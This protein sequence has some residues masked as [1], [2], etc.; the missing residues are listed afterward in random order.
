MSDKI[1][2]PEQYPSDILQ[3]IAVNQI[4]YGV[5]DKKIAVVLEF[6]GEMYLVNADSNEAVFKAEAKGPIFDNTNKVNV[7]HFDFSSVTD[8][9]NYYIASEK[10]RSYTFAI[11][12]KPIHDVSYAILRMLYFQ[13]CSCGLDEKYAGKYKHG[14][15]HNVAAIY[16][17]DERLTVRDICGGWH[18]AGDYGRYITPANQCIH[19]LMYAHELFGSGVDDDFNIPETGS[20]LPDILSEAK[21]EIKWMLKMQ[22]PQGGVYH[23]V[24]TTR[25]AGNDMPEND[26]AEDNPMVLSQISLQATAGF[27]AAMAAAYRAYKPY[28]GQFADTLLAAAKRAYD[29]A[30]KNENNI[31]VE[32]KTIAPGG[33]GTYGDLCCYDEY[34]WA[35][36]E[37][38]RSTGDKKYEEKFKHYYELDFPKTAC[39]A[40]HQGGYGS[41]A[42]CLCDNADEQL[43][44][45]ILKIITDR[46]DELVKISQNDGYLVSLTD[47]DYYWGSNAALFNSL[48]IMVAAAI[49]NKTDKYDDCLKD[50]CAYLFGRNIISQS[51][52]TGF[53][54]KRPMHPHHRP[55]MF[56]G[57]ED[58]VPGMVIGGPNDRPG[59]RPDNSE[60][61]PSAACYID[62]EWNWTTNE[63]TIYWNTAALFI[64]GYLCSKE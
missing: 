10:G 43:K 60:G 58:P 54:S 59:Q 64:T 62:W 57:V 32:F 20:E 4:A 33:G 28:D 1:K 63:V 27:A 6:G 34:Y 30:I 17:L 38:F 49:L 41:I 18:D 47:F 13:R 52:V 21:H 19:N 29:F 26:F 14:K 16:C 11:S 44:A 55:S 22:T 46:A 12:K 45:E 23:K 3:D 9:G 31:M 48:A 36:A 24:C 15:C 42:Y 5:N 37:L 56:D 61:K 8:E 50:N 40:Y 35:S 7:Y 51:Y 25:F 53:G 39:G 2:V